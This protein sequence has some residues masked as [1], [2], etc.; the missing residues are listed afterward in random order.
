MLEREAFAIGLQ[1]VGG[2]EG[3]LRQGLRR[4]GI[5]MQAGERAV[6]SSI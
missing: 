5:A 4:R 3:L 2:A 1:L 6:R